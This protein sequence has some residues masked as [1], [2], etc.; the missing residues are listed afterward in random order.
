MSGRMITRTVG[1][2]FALAVALNGCHGE[3]NGTQPSY[4]ELSD[5]DS[6]VTMPAPAPEP[7]ALDADTAGAR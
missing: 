1:A 7:P 3:T 4:T 2:A 6:P 5:A